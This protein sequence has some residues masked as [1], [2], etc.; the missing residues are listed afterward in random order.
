[1]NAMMLHVYHNQGG[2][3]RIRTES[4]RI[5]TNFDDELRDIYDSFYQFEIFI[6]LSGSFGEWVNYSLTAEKSLKQNSK[7]QSILKHFDLWNIKYYFL[8]RHFWFIMY[9]HVYFF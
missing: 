2:I 8:W 3:N 4:I 6:L 9:L 7:N 1:M 5:N